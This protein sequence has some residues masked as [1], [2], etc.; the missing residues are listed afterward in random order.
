MVYIL[1]MSE[2][3]VSIHILFEYGNCCGNIILL[4]IILILQCTLG[5]GNVVKSTWLV[6]DPGD[7]LESFVLKNQTTS[8]SNVVPATLNGPVSLSLC[9]SAWNAL[10]NIEEWAFIFPSSGPSQWTSGRTPSWLK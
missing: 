8:V 10:V 6:H 9:S 7:Y 4:D 1:I 3:V 5:E 2:T